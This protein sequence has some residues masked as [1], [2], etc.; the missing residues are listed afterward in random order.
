MRPLVSVIYPCYNAE[1]YLSH[2]LESILDQHYSNLEVIC[3]DDGST[4]GTLQLLKDFQTADTRISIIRNNSNLGLIESLNQAIAHVKGDFFARMDAD[5]YC[6]P[7]RITRQMD[8]ISKFP[9]YS[10]VSS[11][12][13]YFIENN[14]HLEQV[15]PIG[16]LPGS[17]RFVS[18]FSTPLTHASVLGRTSLLRNGQYRYDK[19][20]PHSEDYELFSRLALAGILMGNLKDALYWVRLN[21]ESVS[22]LFNDVQVKSHLNITKRNL[23]N[24]GID[25][26]RLSP[27][28]LKLVSNRINEPA[29]EADLRAALKILKECHRRY[30]SDNALSRAEKNEIKEYLRL[31]SVNILIQSN[32]VGFRF[33]GKKNLGFF[34]NTL[35]MLKPRS[36]GKIAHKIIVYLKF[37]IF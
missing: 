20:F 33:R 17:L 6:P 37:R 30:L 7:D 12:Y 18:L 35:L 15:P 23:L 9:E 36:F 11:G 27:G 3:F 4:D 29:N 14:K 24:F 16:T 8:F 10:L 34:T 13:Y 22:V 32:K 1:K 25:E 21:P 2:S 28:I 19:Q 5:D 31:H 26:S